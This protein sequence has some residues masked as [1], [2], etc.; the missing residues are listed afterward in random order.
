MKTCMVSESLE[1][2]GRWRKQKHNQL[3]CNSQTPSRR[4]SEYWWYGLNRRSRLHSVWGHVS[5]ETFSTVSKRCEAYLCCYFHSFFLFY[6]A[7]NIPVVLRRSPPNLERGAHLLHG[8][9]LG[10]WPGGSAFLPS[11]CLGFWQGH[12]QKYP[13]QGD[14][15]IQRVQRK[16]SKGRLLDPENFKWRFHSL[17]VAF[18]LWKLLVDLCSV[19]SNVFFIQ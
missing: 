15:W 1:G 14:F 12:C 7:S 17:N 5:A 6:K 8:C 19:V 16:S 3:N 11:A 10:A 13:C 9:Q 18:T 4:A 2:P